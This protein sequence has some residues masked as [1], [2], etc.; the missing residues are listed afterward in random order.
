MTAS[1]RVRQ[2]G[3][4]SKMMA[5]ALSNCQGWPRTV[6]LRPCACASK[7]ALSRATMSITLAAS[8]SSADRRRD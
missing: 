2:S 1:R 5:P 6:T 3:G 4:A 8:A 7:P